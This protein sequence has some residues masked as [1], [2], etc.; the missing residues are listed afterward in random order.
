MTSYEHEIFNYELPYLDMPPTGAMW[1]DATRTDF[2]NE[3]QKTG[4]RYYLINLYRIGSNPNVTQQVSLFVFKTCMLY[5]HMISTRKNDDAVSS[6]KQRMIR[7]NLSQREMMAIKNSVVFKD[8]ENMTD[9]EWKSIWNLN[10]PQ[11]EFVGS[12]KWIEMVTHDPRPA[13]EI[14]ARFLYENPII[15]TLLNRIH[16]PSVYSSAPASNEVNENGKTETNK[17]KKGTK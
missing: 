15:Q 17:G 5:V 9:D 6:V 7:H 2:V 1:S 3:L 8:Q 11:K 16:V 12:K 14:L 4:R 10:D 13:D